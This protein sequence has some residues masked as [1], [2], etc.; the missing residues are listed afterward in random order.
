M[1]L[2]DFFAANWLYQRRYWMWSG[3]LKVFG[4]VTLTYFLLM[5]AITSFYDQISWQL[6]IFWLLASVLFGL[7]MAVFLPVISWVAM[8]LSVKRTFDQLSLGLPVEYEIDAT[9]FRAAN[10][11]G[12]TTLAWDNLY[13]FVQDRRLLLLR[14]TRRVFFVLPKAQLSGEEL[15]T[16]L[17]RLRE[18][19][20]KEG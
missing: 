19:G 4:F 14:R 11:Q 16:L 5:L 9:R 15:G 20:V 6:V 7:G 17:G 13:D 2:D 3:L 10:E 18:A 1:S 8:R 12:T